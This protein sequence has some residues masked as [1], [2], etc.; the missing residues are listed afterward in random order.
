MAKQDSIRFI[1]NICGMRAPEPVLCVRS[2]CVT[3]LLVR[4][5]RQ[6]LL[7]FLPPRKPS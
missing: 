2:D 6:S 4:D 3:E 5:L 7:N 1:C